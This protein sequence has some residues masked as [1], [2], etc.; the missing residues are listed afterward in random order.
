MKFRWF[1]FSLSAVHAQ[2]YIFSST[3][4]ESDDSLLLR[5]ESV[6]CVGV[7]LMPSF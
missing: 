2:Q 4:S 7:A 5:G 6:L 1:I 3:L